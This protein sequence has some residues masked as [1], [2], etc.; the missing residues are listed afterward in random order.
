MENEGFKI[1]NTT[2]HKFGLKARLLILIGK[3]LKQSI[4]ITVDKEVEVLKTESSG[5]IEDL[6]LKKSDGMLETPNKKREWYNEEDIREFYYKEHGE[7][8]TLDAMPHH[9]AIGLM[10]ESLGL[11]YNKEKGMW[12]Y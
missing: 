1:Y 5:Y 7:S 8:H 4:T 12:E 2:E 6:F 11:T 3:S 10:A 9:E